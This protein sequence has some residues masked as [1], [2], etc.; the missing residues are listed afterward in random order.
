MPLGR[1]YRLF[2]LDGELIASL[3]YWDDGDYTG[4]LPS[5]AELHALAARVR[6]RFFTMD[7]AELRAEGW[8][9][10]EIGEPAE[11]EASS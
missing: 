5:A 6:S 2:F 8:T 9:V 10:I 3:R 1:E 4:A 11:A 7:V